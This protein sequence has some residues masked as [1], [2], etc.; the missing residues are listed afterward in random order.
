MCSCIIYDAHVLMA[1]VITCIGA[2][3]TSLPDVSFS[4]VTRLPQI[5]KIIPAFA[6]GEWQY[7]IDIE[8]HI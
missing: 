5:H 7:Y 3:L 2:F 4:S 8:N 6:F 1:K